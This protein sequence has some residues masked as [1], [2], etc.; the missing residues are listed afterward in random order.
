MCKELYLLLELSIL[1]IIKGE[2]L[3]L[4]INGDIENTFTRN[5]KEYIFI[6]NPVRHSVAVEL[7]QKIHHGKLA[8]VDNVEISQFLAVALSETDLEEEALWIAGKLVEGEWNCYENYKEAQIFSKDIKKMLF[9][10]TEFLN[11]SSNYCLG[12]GRKKF[13]L[14]DFVVSNCNVLRAYMCERSVG[15]VIA[16]RSTHKN[17]IT[18]GS[19]LYK[20]VQDKSS[21]AEANHKCS[22]Y[23]LEAS[24]AVVTNLNSAKDL[25]RHLLIGRPSLQS[26]WIGARYYENQYVFK[27]ENIVLPIKEEDGYPPWIHGQA[28]KTTNSSC[29]LLQQT[30]NTSFYIEAFCERKRSFICYKNIKNKQKSI[31]FVDFIIEKFGYRVFHEKL[32]WEGA[33]EKCGCYIFEGK[34][35]EI[36]N[37][38]VVSHMLYLM[39]QINVL[40]NHLWLGGRFNPLVQKWIWESDK[41]PIN[42]NILWWL[43]NTTYLPY[44]EDSNVCLNMDRE[45]HNNALHYGTNCEY[46]QNFICSFSAESLLQ[47]QEAERNDDTVLNRSCISL[48]LYE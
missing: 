13:D 35:A 26:A 6:N 38:Q 16:T 3:E 10:A 34:L 25:A 18:V 12:I 31:N 17:W 11:T 22:L 42:L 15:T 44:L 23:D 33:L 28:L 24:L 20:I 8:I 1:I 43:K 41:K 47:L 9:P 21:W 32:S 46:L 14:P 45:D 37:K 48:D 39:G 40:F 2:N 36:R 29:L 7:C 27:K 30:A 4:K 19:R 5:E